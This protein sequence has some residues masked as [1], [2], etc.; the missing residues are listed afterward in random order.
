[1]IDGNSAPDDIFTRDLT[2]ATAT[3]AGCG[4]TGPVAGVQVYEGMGSVLRCPSCDSVLMR[5]VSLGDATCLEMRGITVLRWRS[6]G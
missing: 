6:A 5:V 1:M 2:L 3:C 4:V